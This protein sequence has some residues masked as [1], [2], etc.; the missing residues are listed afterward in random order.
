[1]LIR[2]FRDP[3]L[4][5]WVELEAEDPTAQS[6]DDVIALRQDGRIDYV[7]VKFTVDADTY[8]LDWEWLL[9]RKSRGTSMLAKWANAFARA[10]LRAPIASAALCTNRRPSADFAACL[11]S[12]YVDLDRLEP[13]WRT[14]VEE[15]CG[16]ADQARA[17][18]DAF[19]FVGALPDLAKFE[20]SLRDQLVPGDTDETGWL[21][22]REEVRRWATFR[23]SPPPDGKI[24]REHLIQ[25]ITRK[26]PLPIRQ[27]FSV[28]EHY[29]PPSV[30][31]D[32]LLRA[33]AENSDTP[34][35]VIWGSPGRGKSTYLS[36]LT[37]Q[38]QAA[39][40]VV[41]RHHY[42]LPNDQ[43]GNRTS[44][45]EIAHSLLHQL[46]SQRHDL[47]SDNP[48]DASALRQA[49]E[50]AALTLKGDGVKLY[51]IVDGLDHVWRDTDRVDQLNHLFNTILPL[52][53]NFV[54]LVGTQR[55][56]DAQ[57]PKALLE[58]AN[59]SDW[60]EIP[61]MDEAAVHQW[62]RHQD[63]DRPLRLA[64][65]A[66]DRVA[67][68]DAIAGALFRISAGH[69]L[70][71][72]FSL[73][74]LRLSGQPLRS[75]LVEALP[76]CPDGDIR[77][78]YRRLWISLSEC[79]RDL[80]HGLSGS[81]FYWPSEGVRTCFGNYHEIAFLL[82]PRASALSPFHRSLFA[83]SGNPTITTKCIEHCYRA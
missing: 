37:T 40:S 68:I 9:A 28:P 33:R 63:S 80:L 25:L 31:F 44:F 3:N 24:L 71:L 34:L 15:E 60:L 38:L 21:R 13:E 7:Q 11:H 56:P 12:H 77:N 29:T 54:L 26:R 36:Y 32:Q 47:V 49:L 45:F 66:G 53:D 83:W 8:P 78:Y 81:D 51:L 48:D 72:I 79:A 30:T 43:A 4:Y 50:Q 27:D 23:G 74:S 20:R 52:P 55:V 35:T 18:F 2:H 82:E 16:G 6:L 41:L 5:V 10:R 65:E 1:M 17:F 70:H 67:E 62:V 58:Q 42:F 75:D 57:L 61:S 69:P 19:A 73:E 39:K 46:A 76:P 22:L 59:L 64:Y 14:K